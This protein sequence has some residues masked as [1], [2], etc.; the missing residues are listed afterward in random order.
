MG[1]CRSRVSGWRVRRTALL[2]MR[3]L[4]GGD[5]AYVT[6]A[7]VVERSSLG[8]LCRFATSLRLS[9][10]VPRVGSGTSRPFGVFSVAPFT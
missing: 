10:N 4:R 9:K 6:P 8:S 5:E 3:S 7:P 1:T 2:W